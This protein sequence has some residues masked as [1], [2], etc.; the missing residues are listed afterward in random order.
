MGLSYKQ[1]L[2]I[3][4]NKL[5][6]SLLT[7]Y[8][9][10]KRDYSLNNP[11]FATYQFV[12]EL[13]EQKVDSAIRSAVQELYILAARKTVEKDIG[14]DFFLTQRD[15]LTIDDLTRRYQTWFWSGLSRELQHQTAYT[16]DGKT[17]LIM[18]KTEVEL[19][20]T[21]IGRLIGS[22]QSE[23]TSTAVVS[24][25]RQ[26]FI[27]SGMGNV[28]GRIR[29]Q[30]FFG[31][32]KRQKRNYTSPQIIWTTGGTESTCPICSTFEGESFEISDLNM[33]MPVLNT[34]PNCECELVLV[35]V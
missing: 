10:A 16:Y 31:A 1:D 25:S 24:K 18:Q 34:H 12:K 30:G 27:N 33:P 17:G 22:I 20:N 9:N 14:L 8:D 15:I 23:V 28:G 2:K 21:F 3:Q 5:K 13:Q 7:A 11:G 35:G 4:T 29:T 32:A 6:K 19:R 26:L